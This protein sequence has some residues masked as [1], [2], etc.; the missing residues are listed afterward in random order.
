M[1]EHGMIN[2][3]SEIIDISTSMAN[4]ISNKT[5]KTFALHQLFC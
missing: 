3:P 5:L 1:E 2:A 4:Y